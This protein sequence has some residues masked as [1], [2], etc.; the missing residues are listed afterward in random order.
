VCVCVSVCVF[1][2]VCV[3]SC[4]HSCLRTSVCVRCACLC[5]TRICIP[6]YNMCTH[7][8]TRTRVSVPADAAGAGRNSNWTS[9]LRSESKTAINN[10]HRRTR[11]ILFSYD[12]INTRLRGRLRYYLLYLFSAK[13]DCADTDTRENAQTLKYNYP[14][15][16]ARSGSE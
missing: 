16:R 6:V 4:V 1:A 13:N 12:V 10:N 3:S 7:I 15:F 11:V 14:R 5:A 2:C 9:S 8:H